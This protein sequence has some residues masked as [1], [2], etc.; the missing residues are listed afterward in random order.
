MAMTDLIH[1]DL[2]ERYGTKAYSSLTMHRL[3]LWLFI[4]SDAFFFTALIS[5]RYF[6]S[7]TDRPDALIQELGLALTAVLL[8]SSLSAYRSEVAASHGDTEGAKRWIMITIIAGFVFLGGVVFEWYEAF[9]DFPPGSGF[10]TTFFTLTGIHTTH[11]ISGIIL[12]AFVY[13]RAAKG[14][15]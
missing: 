2:H 11:V 7:G 8:L 9:H 12:L 14:E 5:S 4:I 10:G 6:V 3:G 15:Y 1:A 13:R